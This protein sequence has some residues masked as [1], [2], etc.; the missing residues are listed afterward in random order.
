MPLKEGKSDK[1][2]KYNLRELIHSGKKVKQ[3]LA[4]S[5]AKKREAGGK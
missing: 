1:A 2:F 5:F 3:A 4:I